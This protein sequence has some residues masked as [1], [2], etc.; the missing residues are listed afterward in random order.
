MSEYTT[1]D[2]KEIEEMQAK[3]VRIIGIKGEN[4]T[5]D[6]DP[7]PK[8]EKSKPTPKPERPVVKDEK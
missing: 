5:F 8:P 4:V 3:G 1:S 6:K 7:K 2:E